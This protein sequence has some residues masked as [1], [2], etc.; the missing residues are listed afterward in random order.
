MKVIEQTHELIS[1]PDN[2]LE[3]LEKAGRTCYK[4]E[5]RITQDSAPKFVDMLVRKKHHA[6]IEFGDIIVRLTTNR[7]VTHEMVRHRLCSFAQESTRYVKY[8]GKMA[9]IRPVWSDKG[10]LGQWDQDGAIPERLAQGDQIWLKSM[11]RAEAEYAQLIQEG[12]KA[13]AAREI[14]PNSLKTEIVVKANIREW[15][16]IFALRCAKSS[17]PQMVALMQPLLADLKSKLPVVFD[18]LNV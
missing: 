11:L 13:Q 16:H 8:D 1:L 5:A 9:F 3:T 12:W 2:L 7:G 14:L 15:R 10:L 17:H 18:D 6:M 4:S